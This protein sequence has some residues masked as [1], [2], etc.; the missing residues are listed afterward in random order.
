MALGPDPAL[1]RALAEALLIVAAKMSLDSQRPSAEIAEAEV[2]RWLT[3]EEAASRLEVCVKTLSRRWRK[4]PF[5]HPLPGGIR[6][7]RVNAREL[8]QAMQKR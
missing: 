7:Y 5:C 6:G 2:E 4:L 1:L 3:P 8:E